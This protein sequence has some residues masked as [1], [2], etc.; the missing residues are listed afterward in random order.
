[1]T[2]SLQH[3]ARP[4]SGPSPAAQGPSP[5]TAVSCGLP[6]HTAAIL[7]PLFLARLARLV[8][9]DRYDAVVASLG[10]PARVGFRLNPLRAD[11]E[12]TL[13]GLRAHGLDP[14]PVAWYGHAFTVD[15]DARAALVAAPEYAAGAVYL[16]NLSSMVPPVALAPEAGERIL[17][18]AAAPG[19]KTT[20]LA[21]LTG[22]AA[23][24]AAVELVRDR[25]F[26]LRANLAL[27][28]AE[29]RTFLQDGT[30]VHR[31]R[32]E[33]FDRVL[34]DAPCSTE[35][36]FR[37][38]VPETFAYWSERKIREMQRRQQALLFSAVNSLAV[39]GV[40][41]YA[42]CS[43]APEENEE[44]VDRALTAFGDALTLEPLPIDVPAA[45]PARSEWDGTSFA[46]DLSPARRLLPDGTYEAFFVARFRKTASTVEPRAER[47]GAGK[48]RGD[49]GRTDKSRSDERSDGR[50]GRR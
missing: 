4:A 41:V 31:Y 8:P 47:A 3:P 7:P 37:A 10:P 49:K 25:F 15:A 50:R 13:H 32:P 11:P 44:V 14:Q 28:G 12:A 24:I 2:A 21:A 29:A 42:T 22:N 20:Q 46:H 26:R 40:L 34:L 18:L 43:F 1:M 6:F 19:S 38:D 23:E 36:R 16:Q 35:G 48:G 45:M 30:K 27:A 33:H 9:E 5:G 39:G 17:D